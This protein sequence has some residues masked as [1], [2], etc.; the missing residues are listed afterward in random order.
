[1]TATQEPRV[2]VLTLNLHCWQE[3]DAEAKLLRIADAIAEFAPDIVCLQEVGQHGEAP[4][5][6]M[7]SG[8]TI[9]A[10]NAALLIVEHLERGHSLAYDWAWTFAHMGFGEWEEGLAILTRGALTRIDAPFVS[11]IPSHQQ[12]NSRRLLIA[13]VDLQGFGVITAASAHFSWWDDPDEPFAPQFDRADAALGAWPEPVVLAGDF[14]VRDDGPGLAHILATGRWTDAH[15]QAL[16]PEVPS[17]TFPG[18][19]AGWSGAEAGRIDYVLTNGSRLRAVSARTLFDT[20]ATR[21]SDHFGLLVDFAAD[22]SSHGP[23]R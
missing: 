16:A 15:A 22:R 13:E 20:E 2:R 19:I 4:I 14:N 9:R 5:V 8:E 11:S 7:H 21:V 6:G 12:W 23:S 3:S 18:N 17:G 10:D 1:M